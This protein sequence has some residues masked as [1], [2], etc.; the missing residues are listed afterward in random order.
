MRGLL[1]NHNPG[2]P[3]P[4]KDDVAMAKGIATAAEKLGILI[5]DHIVLGRKSHASLHSFGLHG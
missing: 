4:P 3:T 2:H 5:H 1:H